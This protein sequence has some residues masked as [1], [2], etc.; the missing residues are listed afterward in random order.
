MPRQLYIREASRLTGEFVFT[1][2]DLM[3]NRRKF[4][5]IGMAGYHIDIREARGVSVRTFYF[6]KA[7][8]QVCMDGYFG[9]SVEPRDIPYRALLPHFSEYENLLVPGCAGA[10][11]AVFASFRM[12]PRYVISGHTAGV[13]AALAGRKDTSGHPVPIPEL[14]RLL[15]EDGQVLDL[16]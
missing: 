8:D 3:T 12:E 6:P 10:F 4:G 15:R 1:H 14:Q 7:E 9:R 11:T 16:R 13:A 5:C 2:H